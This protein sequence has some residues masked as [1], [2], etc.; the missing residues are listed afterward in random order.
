M[1]VD[2]AIIP[3]SRF[4]MKLLDTQSKGAPPSRWAESPRP[5][6]GERGSYRP[7]A[8]TDAM[9]EDGS[10]MS[11]GLS[12]AMAVEAADHEQDGT[13][14]ASSPDAIDPAAR[15]CADDQP[16]VSRDRSHSS[17]MEMDN[18]EGRHAASASVEGS[19]GGV[20]RESPGVPQ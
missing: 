8:D 16:E 9:V 20:V 13:L 11:A 19:S 12:A 3:G 4:C 7:M 10:A 2:R 18:A 15:T 6:P 5:L 17:E 1:Y 14:D